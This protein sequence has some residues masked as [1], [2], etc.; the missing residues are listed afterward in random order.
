MNDMNGLVDRVLV[1]TNYAIAE[2]RL[3][4]HK[5]YDHDLPPLFVDPLMIEQVLTNLILNAVQ[6]TGEGGRS[7]CKP[8]SPTSAVRST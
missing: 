4:L 2:K 5:V 6:A 3:Q 7:S 8:G 1:L